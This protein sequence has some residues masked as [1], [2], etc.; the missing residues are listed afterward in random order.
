MKQKGF[1]LVEL[2]IVIAIFAIITSV[3]LYNQNRFS[4]DISISNITYQIALQ[5][6][7]A[8]VYGT[9][10]R[11]GEVPDDFNLGYGVTFFK[12]VD[13]TIGGFRI[14]ADGDPV[15]GNGVQ[16]NGKYD[17]GAQDSVIS[18]FDL[19]E[20]NTITEVCV[21]GSGSNSSC[22]SNED[23]QV[24]IVFRR[25][26]PDA[27][28]SSDTTEGGVQRAEIT[29]TSAL[30]DKQKLITVRSTGQISV[31]NPPSLGIE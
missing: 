20:G 10:V 14:F 6:R 1:S 7:Q 17:E 25:P 18:T 13:G 3:V 29:I 26:E 16:G 12:D 21:Y 19:S 22:M 24:D 4:S 2:I 11:Q 9:L 5:I 30:G 27:I 31:T 23:S 15:S 28:I 8:Q